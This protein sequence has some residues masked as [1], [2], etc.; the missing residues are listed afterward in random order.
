[1]NSD[2]LSIPAAGRPTEAFDLTKLE[3]LLAEDESSSQERHVSKKQL[4]DEPDFISTTE[5]PQSNDDFGNNRRGRKEPFETHTARLHPV[6]DESDP[7]TFESFNNVYLN[8]LYADADSL[9]SL[10]RWRRRGH[11]QHIADIKL[12]IKTKCCVSGC[13]EPED[14]YEL[15]NRLGLC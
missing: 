7:E 14:Y 2:L 11:E 6:H 13:K 1:M 9:P 5:R 8:P 4:S 15:S 12:F 3:S 10:E